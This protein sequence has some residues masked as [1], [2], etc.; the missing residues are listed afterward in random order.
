MMHFI[1]IFVRSEF[2]A[3]FFLFLYDFKEDRRALDACRDSVHM[4]PGLFLRFN[5][6]VVCFK[7]ALS[8]FSPL[9]TTGQ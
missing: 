8:N 9:H 2:G 7:S 3:A 1:I 4:S 5:E 6:P